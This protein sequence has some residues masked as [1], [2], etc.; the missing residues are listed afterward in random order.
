MD[1]FRS[2]MRYSQ[3]KLA[4]LLK[5]PSEGWTDEDAVPE[6]PDDPITVGG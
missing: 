5:K 4:E 1:Q 6:M 2:L 3:D